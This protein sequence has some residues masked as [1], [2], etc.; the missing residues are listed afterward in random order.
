VQSSRFAG[1]AA[2]VTLEREGATAGARWH[3]GD[4]PQAGETLHVKLDER[5]CS[6]ASA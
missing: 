3:P 4:A 2:L 5:F 6:V 1:H